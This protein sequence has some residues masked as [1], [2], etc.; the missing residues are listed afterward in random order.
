M[1]KKFV[2]VVNI[3]IVLA[4]SLVSLVQVGGAKESALNLTILHTNDEHS[5][6]IPFNPAID[7]TPDVG[8]DRT[9][10]GFARLA[11]EI[12]R[13]RADKAVTDEPVLT[14]SAGDFLMGTMFSWLGRRGLTPELSLMRLMGY[15]AITLGNHEFDWGSEYLARYLSKAGYPEAATSMPIVA[16]N[17]VIPEG[18]PLGK[19]GIQPYVVKELPNGIKVGIFGILGFEA[20]LISVLAAPVTFSDPGKTAAEMVNV[21]TTLKVD[22]II[23]LSHSGV[24]ED[25]AMARKVPGI[26]IIVGGHSHSALFEPIMVG[27]TIIVQ[28]GSCGQYLGV[29]ELSVSENEEVSIRNYVAGNPFLIFIDDSVRA[30]R[31]VSVIIDRV[32]VKA[33][34]RMIYRLTGGMFNEILDVVAESGFDLLTG[35]TFMETGLGNLITDS[36]RAAVDIFQNYDKVDFA[37]EA[38]GVIRGSVLRGSIP[39]KAGLI[40]LYDLYAVVSLGIGLD[41]LPGFP[42]S[43]F[44]LTAKEIKHI[45]EVSVT[46]ATFI[47]NACFVQASGLRFRYNT[48]EVGTFQAVTKIEQY[49]GPEPQS[50]SV[51]YVTLYENG[52]WYVDPRALYRVAVN[53]YGVYL[54]PFIAIVPKDETGKPIDPKATIVHRAPRIELKIWQALLYYVVSFPDLDADGIPDVPIFYAEPMGRVIAN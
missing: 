15:D 22:I 6:V 34:N 33:L 10:G 11:T 25:M 13:I 2:S 41:G 5:A 51:F 9:V 21:L 37:F 54:L 44:Y 7:Y 3:A 36:M 40:S 52:T 39:S 8:D 28:A 32:Y 31:L 45:C 48:T 1:N 50:D 42:L 46:L 26:D 23:C 49:V 20:S 4:F 18:H 43:S 17:I 24:A 14:F 35:P 27:E 47:G 38:N 29:L 12:H 16:S 53:I 19:M 30:S